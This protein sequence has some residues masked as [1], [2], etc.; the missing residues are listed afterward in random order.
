MR[1]R[2]IHLSI[3]TLYIPTIH[4]IFKYGLEMYTRRIFNITQNGKNIGKNCI[5]VSQC[6]KIQF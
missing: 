6:L 3:Y 5:I 2:T 4:I 1:I